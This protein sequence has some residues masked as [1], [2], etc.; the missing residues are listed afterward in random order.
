MYE[1]VGGYMRVR[2][3][4]C[5]CVC[6]CV[7]ARRSRVGKCNNRQQNHHHRWFLFWSHRPLPPNNTPLAWAHTHT[8]SSTLTCT[9]SLAHA[10]TLTLTHS[11]EHRPSR[12]GSTRSSRLGS[13][14]RNCHTMNYCC[15]HEIVTYI[16]VLEIT[17]VYTWHWNLHGEIY[18]PDMRIYTP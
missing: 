13:D 14:R 5:V 3:L 7:H 6:A 8:H 2:V 4:E 16:I 11:P 18:Y 10:L 12:P 15:A 17:W 9:H 1:W